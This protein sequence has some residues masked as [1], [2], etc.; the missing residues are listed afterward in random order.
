[1][2]TRWIALV[3]TFF[4]A[5]AGGWAHGE[6]KHVLGTIEK[7]NGGVLVVKTWENMSV[8]VK[9]VAD[10]VYQ[11]KT[12]AAAQRSDLAAGQ[13]V[14]IHATLKSDH[15]LEADTVKFS[16]APAPATGAPAKK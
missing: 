1:M 11:T 14:V 10:T 12:G 7:I 6:K 16:V 13:R 4:L 15:S 8:E 2:K 5:A 3:L 9:L